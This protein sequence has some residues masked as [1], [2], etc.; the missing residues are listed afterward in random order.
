MQ[1]LE[2]L[3]LFLELIVPEACCQRLQ[4]THKY[5]NLIQ[6]LELLTLLIITICQVACCDCYVSFA[7]L[8]NVAF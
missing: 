4:L 6:I 2:V 7:Y 5:T 3:K 8:L 1:G